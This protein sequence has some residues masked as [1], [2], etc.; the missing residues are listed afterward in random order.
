[1]HESAAAAT[2]PAINTSNALVPIANHH[3][4]K[5]F[6]RQQFWADLMLLFYRPTGDDRAALSA[7]T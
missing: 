4:A 5:P 7:E 1:M 3:A 6:A 2:F